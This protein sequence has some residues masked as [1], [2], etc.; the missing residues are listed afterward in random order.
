MRRDLL[1]LAGAALLPGATLEIG[2]PLAAGTSLALGAA[3]S[4]VLAQSKS[5]V[6]EAA[7][8]SS[9]IDASQ[10]AALYPQQNRFRDLFDASGL[11]DFQI[12]AG[13]VG[14]AQQW[15]RG[16][17]SPRL[18]AVPGSWNDQFPE[19]SNY[20]GTVWYLR[21]LELPQSW[22]GRSVRLR[23]ESANWAAKV[24][25]DGRLLGG[26]EGG[27]LPFEFDLGG[28][29]G[30]PAENRTGQPLLL[31]IRVE[32]LPS[33]LRVPP[34]A[35]GADD[36]AGNFP[37]VAYD[38]FPYAGLQRRVLLLALA[39]RHLRDFQVVTT[40]DG[41]DA[42]VDVT[43]FASDRW[44]GSGQVQ[45]AGNGQRFEAALNFEGGVARARLR[46]AAA[47]LWHPR[48]PHLYAVR[49]ELAEGGVAID[50]YRDEIGLRTVAVRGDRLLLNG[51]P[52]AL[53]G[54]GRHEDFPVNGRG[55]NLPVA[56]NDIALI[57]WTGG[58][59][60]RTSHYPY[61]EETMR[62]A[63]REGMLVIDETPAV[64]LFFADDPARIDTR[65]RQVKQQVR[66][67]I[68]RDKNRACVIMWSLANE[69]MDNGYTAAAMRAQ[70]PAGD[71]YREL[72]RRFFEELFS[73]ARSLD[74]SRPMTLAGAP[75]SDPSWLE[76]SDIICVN[77]YAGWYDHH[78]RLDQA[79]PGLIAEIDRLH[80][81]T[82]K[83]VMFSEFG[84]DAIAGDH[85]ASAEIW[86]EEYQVQLIR[87]YLDL[88]DARPWI[89]GMH[90]WNLA[91]FRTT[92][93]L[94]RPGGINHKG[95]FTR[96]RR[97]KMAAHYLRSRWAGV[98]S[99]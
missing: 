53:R 23:I 8:S 9:G 47:R 33:P 75:F 92:Q 51:E 61:S 43:A 87:R 52:I 40:L 16:L 77:R 31:A 1:R 18:I 3:P 37:N 2:A 81:R 29:S 7:P 39:P 91:D 36:A 14:E 26:H 49:F 38:F 74:R 35:I 4:N 50:A 90:I 70:V 32:N 86:S 5:G 83:P 27:H 22:N 99:P 96:D 46:V 62:L 63:D 68:A 78:G 24:W 58:N 34:G 13:D 76:Q 82:G 11:W 65:L 45:L 69:P 41:R 10:P 42:I 54:F 89:V 20:L 88:A 71:Q 56:V 48:D 73:Y 55:T 60:F 85:S 6:A 98:A 25:L 95:V 66:E 19:L 15:Y 44:S 93:A 94:G 72:G 21:R 57:R 80:A 59:S 84:A 28:L 97:P 12:D 67:L 17:P 79:M 64:G 30:S